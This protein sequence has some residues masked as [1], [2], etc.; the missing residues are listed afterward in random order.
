MAVMLRAMQWMIDDAA[1]A[2]GRGELDPDS[3]AQLAT[4]LERT[5]AS[6]RAHVGTGR[7]EIRNEPHAR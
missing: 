2:A 6:V 5:A 1:Y 7:L 3:G 4:Q